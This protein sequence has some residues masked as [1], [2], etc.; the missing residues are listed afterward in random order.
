VVYRSIQIEKGSPGY[1][2]VNPNTNIIYISYQSSNFILAVDLTKGTVRAK[3]PAH[4]PGNIVVNDSTNKVYV[5]SAYGICEINGTNNQFD[6]INIG[7]PH[8]DGSVA[9]NPSTNLLYTTCFGHD[10][11]TV[12]D[13]A[14]QA[15]A[16]KIPVGINPK[17]VAVDASG[18][19][20]YVANRDS[21]SISIIDGDSKKVIDNLDLRSPSREYSV[22]PEV[23]IANTSS[24]L[25]YIQRSGVMSAGSGGTTITE[26]LVF[27]TIMKTII[28]QRQIH[29][30]PPLEKMT[31]AF[32][33]GNNALYTTNFSL[34]FGHIVLKLDSFAKEE[35]KT[36]NFKTNWRRRILSIWG[37]VS[38]LVTINTLTNKAYVTDS[39]SN[40]LYELDG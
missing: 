1:A 34:R 32:N 9:L 33:S 36:W 6:I 10:I 18:N 13:I 31:F 28:N 38:E 30:G 5:S 20:I 29:T 37:W 39:R 12:I 14:T 2:I 15:I 4:S 25:L 19:K 22:W 26:L 16:D 27:D 3:I 7:L 23:I 24:K 17:G 8:T 21:N 40:V 11:L 35:L